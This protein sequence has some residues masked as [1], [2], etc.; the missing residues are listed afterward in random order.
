MAFLNVEFQYHK[1]F[2]AIKSN[3]S[4]LNYCS[5]YNIDPI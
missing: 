2:M 1:S 4:S 3:G 5:K